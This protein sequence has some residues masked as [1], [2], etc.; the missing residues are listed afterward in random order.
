MLNEIIPIEISI[1]IETSKPNEIPIENFSY[2]LKSNKI[3]IENSF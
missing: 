2:S 3:L 1:L